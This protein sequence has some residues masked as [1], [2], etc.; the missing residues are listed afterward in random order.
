MTWRFNPDV[1]HATL[2]GHVTADG[3]IALP[4]LLH[5]PGMGSLRVF[6]QTGVKAGPATLGYVAHRRPTRFVDVTFPAATQ[7]EGWVE[8]TLRTAAI[9]PAVPGVNLMDRRYDGFRRDWLDIF[10]Q[11]AEQHVLANNAAS[12]AVAF[13][14]FLYADMARFT[15]RL[16]PGLTA[17]DL[18]RETLD[19][20]LNGFVGYGMPGYQLFDAPLRSEQY[21]HASLD[22]YPSLLI[23]ACDYVDAT[24]DRAWLR[25]HYAGLRAWAV[26]M[27]EP[28]ADGSP[29]LES[30]VSG[31]S[32]SWT[33][34]VTLRP[35]NW[36]TRSGLD[37]RT[38]TPMRW[39]TARC[40]GWPCW[41]RRRATPLAQGS[42]GSARRRCGRRTRRRLWTRPRAWLPDGAAA[43]GNCT[44]TTS[45]L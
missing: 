5:L 2:L 17:L 4:A 23:A 30:P 12:D 21:P 33:P 28:N 10:Q 36:W 37:T 45:P 22:T 26:K 41:L 8:Y 40:A 29:L 43:T 39:A 32:G 6:A 27:T 9:Y 7:A 3:A 11:Q 42:T 31:D 34:K 19:R 15:P 13:T 25:A 20:Y 44:I 38:H 24:G 16:A 35:A 14:V 18:V 1:T